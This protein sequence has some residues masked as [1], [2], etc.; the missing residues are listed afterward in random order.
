MD[1]NRYFCSACICIIIIGFVFGL[2]VA[3]IFG[4]GGLT[5]LGAALP[6]VI[7]VAVFA[8]AVIIGI[9]AAFAF[10]RNR[11]GVVCCVFRYA[12]CILIAAGIAII[13]SILGLALGLTAASI[14]SQ[15]LVFFI[16]AS[17]IILL[18]ALLDLVRCIILASIRM[19]TRDDTGR[20]EWRG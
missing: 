15:V 13:A 4:M 18:I 8:L 3:V 11:N 2:L 17:F 16:A 19:D 6:A 7:G 10:T 1:R 9:L 5:A 14:L 12:F 20:N